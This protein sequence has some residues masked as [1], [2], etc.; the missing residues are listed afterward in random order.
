MLR[1]LFSTWKS[2]IGRLTVV[3]PGGRKNPVNHNRFWAGEEEGHFTDSFSTVWSHSERK[4]VS[5]WMADAAAVVCWSDEILPAHPSISCECPGQIPSLSWQPTS[6]CRARLAQ[7]EV[8]GSYSA[9]LP[10][11][12]TL[13]AQLSMGSLTRISLPSDIDEVPLTKKE[14]DC[15]TEYFLH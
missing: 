1:N 15:F 8:P 7:S 12:S 13:S 2:R 9:N 3:C 14:E 6:P 11:N 4:D 5:S 10:A